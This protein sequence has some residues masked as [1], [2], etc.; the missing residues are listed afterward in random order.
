MTKFPRDEGSLRSTKYGPSAP[1]KGL[2][3]QEG[4]RY[5]LPVA[6]LGCNFTGGLKKGTESVPFQLKDLCD[7]KLFEN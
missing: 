1:S 2:S 3:S 5:D 7:L 6:R 4:G